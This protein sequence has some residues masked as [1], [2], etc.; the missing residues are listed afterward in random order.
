MIVIMKSRDTRRTEHVAG[1]EE[2][3]NEENAYIFGGGG[4]YI[5]RK[6]SSHFYIKTIV[7]VFVFFFFYFNDSFSNTGLK[8]RTK[9]VTIVNC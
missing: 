3:N 9:L 5:Y 1:K 2:R 4:I 7:C 6:I 8:R